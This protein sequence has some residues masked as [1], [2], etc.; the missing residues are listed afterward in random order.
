MTV[1]QF[2]TNGYTIVRNALSKELCDFVTQYAFFDEMQ[3]ESN[4]DPQAPNAH[5]RYADP[6]METVLVTLQDKMEQSTGLKLYPTYSY[7]RIY[8]Q[9]DDLKIHKDRNSCEISCT[10]CF[11]YSYED[12]EWPIFMNG[13]RVALKPGDMVVY[14]GM[15]LDHWREPFDINDEDAWH[16]QGFF[17]YVDVNGPN[18]EWKW[19]KR[20]SIGELPVADKSPSTQLPSYIE[21][22]K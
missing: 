11:N 13:N 20:S 3:K 6:V 9:G 12:Y 19:D 5:S 21:Y 17:H 4:Q 1:K 2:Q 18:A 15:D 14:R 16:V 8:G 10:L 7:Y 22:T